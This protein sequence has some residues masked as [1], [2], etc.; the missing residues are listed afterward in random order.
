MDNENFNKKVKKISIPKIRQALFKTQHEK[1]CPYF[2]NS[3]VGSCKYILLRKGQCLAVPFY[4][5][6]KRGQSLNHYKKIPEK[7]STNK[8]THMN[9]YIRIS[10]YHCGMAKKPLMP[11]KMNCSRSQLPINGIIS[12]AGVNRSC[13]ELGNSRLINRKQ[14]KTT[15]K[16][17]FKKL[18]YI[19][20]SNLGI[21]SEMAKASHS[22]INSC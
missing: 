19:P 11:Y 7:L 18:P 16:D 15:Y 10:N 9:D 4:I 1:G 22:K 8:S 3:K 21:T 5:I 6:N 20:I 17:S 2:S 13:L 14:W 12:G